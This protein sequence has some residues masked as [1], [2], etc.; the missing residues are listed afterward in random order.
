MLIKLFHIKCESD[1]I[2]EC[3]QE[4]THRGSLILVQ[5]DHPFASSFRIK[6]VEVVMS[7]KLD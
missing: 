5:I 4:V 7:F 2:H 1:S 3:H 6:G